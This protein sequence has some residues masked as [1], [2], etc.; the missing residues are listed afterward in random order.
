MKF[1]KEFISQM[2]PEWQEAYMDYNNLKILLKEI[3]RFRQRT[4]PLVST[5]S[6]LK[7]KPTLYR[8]FSGLIQRNIKSPNSGAGGDMEDQV[9][10]VR[11]MQSD[12][13]SSSSDHHQVKYRTNF[14][15]SAEEG[16]EYE[17]LYFRR[18]DDELNKVNKFYREKVEEVLKEANQL[19][20]QMDALIAFRIKAENPNIDVESFDHKGEMRRLASEVAASTAASRASTPSGAKTPGSTR[21]SGYMNVIEE[22]LLNN[23][24]NL[25]DSSADI[26]VIELESTKSSIREEKPDSIKGT[27]PTPLQILNHVKLNNTLETPCSTVKG[28]LKIPMNRELNL[29][30]LKKVEGQL[31]QTFI[32]FY[33]K[34]RLLKSYSFL[35]LL[36]FS[37]IMKK[38][39]KTTSRSAARAYLKMVDDS[40]LGSSDEVTRLMERVEATFI[41]HFSN[42]N[43]RKGIKILRP[44]SKKEKHR[45]TFSI[46]FFTGCA[47]AL[48]VALILIIHARHILNK[49]GS[50]QYM[51]TMFPL[52]SLFGFVVLHMVMYGIN[53]YL[54]RRYQVNHPF[55]F[56][57]KQGTELGYREVFL[58]SSGLAV[59]AFSSVLANLN[60]EM[61]LRTKE[62]KSITELVPLGLFCLVLVITFCPF[63]IIY[64][65]SRFFLLRSA[66]HCISAPLYKVTLPDF[67]LADQLTSQVQAIRSLEFYICYYGWGDY[68]HRRNTCKNFHVYQ[69]FFYI[70]SVFPYWS[71]FLQCLR[72]LYEEKD[73]MQG[74]NGLKYFSTILA[75]VM[76]TAYSM[77]NGPHWQV[78][79]AITSAIAAILSTYW[80]LVIDWGLLQRKSK[81]RWLRD[82]LL[83][84]HKSVYFGAMILNVLLRFAWLQ[85]VLNFQVSF[86]HR[87]ALISIVASLEII[88]RGIWNFF[89]LENEHLN[90]V[91]KFRAFRSVPLPF[92]CDEDED[93]DE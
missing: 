90:N 51:E 3:I 87:E 68:I 78:L 92:N 26:D 89:R 41:K 49:K 28:I 60:M 1:G 17:L 20:K 33:Q 21:E 55:I 93:K 56:G 40:Y 54:W 30:G 11:A 81:N 38:Y 47:T 36:A 9:V 50:S 6:G 43:R 10:L 65:S 14:L 34:L 19:T 31:K 16:G 59:L 12:Q 37:K 57:I 84:S 23:G 45:V 69:T 74:Y 29:Q 4:K 15:M 44:K 80:D 7:R 79:A 67:F 72:Q 70:V 83:I 18:L 58:L 71:R 5:P 39:D 73:P 61:D 8:A 86:L 62:Y 76:R 48:L 2:V 85:T 32:E 24:G 35:N 53:I 27:K 13:G 82:K 25:D 46:G 91:G 42:S 63:D 22:F 66:F 88:R 52:Y 75:I 64:R 77:S